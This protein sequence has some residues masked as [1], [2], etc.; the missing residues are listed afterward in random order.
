MEVRKELILFFII[1]LLNVGVENRKGI[2]KG[3]L[4]LRKVAISSNSKR[5]MTMNPHK[6]IKSLFEPTGVAVTPKMASCKVLKT[7][8][9]FV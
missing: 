7:M 1:L 5:L 6:T 3:S 8:G 4:K 9:R 2:L